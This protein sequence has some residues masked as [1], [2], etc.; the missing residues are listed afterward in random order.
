M[1]S[2]TLVTSPDVPLGAVSVVSPL[3][4]SSCVDDEFVDVEP[5]DVVA[6]GLF[7]VSVDCELVSVL[8]DVAKLSVVFSGVDA[9]VD[10]PASRFGDAQLAKS[11][12]VYESQLEPSSANAPVVAARRR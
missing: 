12:Q 6:T 8:S 2:S 9:S 3:D 5:A 1:G 4:G 7:P 11:K 10:E